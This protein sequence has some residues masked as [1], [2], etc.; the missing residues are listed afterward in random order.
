MRA[1]QSDRTT[2]GAYADGGTRLISSF[3]WADGA[4]ITYTP[5]A[6]AIGVDRFNYIIEDDPFAR[7]QGVV[8]VEIVGA[9]G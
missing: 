8:E 7:A 9:G 5:P 4:S 2:Y 3:T 1:A 6:G